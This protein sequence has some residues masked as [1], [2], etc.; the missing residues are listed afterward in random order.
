VF[1]SGC[2][3]LF[4]ERIDEVAR[5]WALTGAQQVKSDPGDADGSA[6]RRAAAPA[7]PPDTAIMFQTPDVILLTF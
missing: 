4:F 3:T 1:A 2:Y 5:G 6:G 7:E